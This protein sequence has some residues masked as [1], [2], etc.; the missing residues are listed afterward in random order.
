LADGV[1]GITYA[2]GEHRQFANQFIP[3]EFEGEK[4]FRPHQHQNADEAQDEAHGLGR[5][6]ALVGQGEM[7]ERDEEQGNSAHQ[8]PGHAG[9]YEMHAPGDD[10]ERK[11]M[12]DEAEPGEFPPLCRGTVK[13]VASERRIGHEGGGGHRKPEARHPAGIEMDDR[14]LAHGKGRAPDGDEG[15][16]SE[17]VEWA[18]VGG[19]RPAMP[20]GLCA[21]NR[22]CRNGT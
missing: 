2:A 8:Q 15:C 12:A 3:R 9:A 21:V 4:L 5:G 13:G 16:E 11:R 1:N 19:H 6:Q 20:Y 7:G 18:G 22:N 10:E 17:P 14:Y